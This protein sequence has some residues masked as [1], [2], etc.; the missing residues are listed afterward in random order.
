MVRHGRY[1]FAT[2]VVG[3]MCVQ[4]VAKSGC[5]GWQFI[6]I[7]ARESGRQDWQELSFI[8]A[9]KNRFHKLLTVWTPRRPGSWVNRLGRRREHGA[10]TRRGRGLT[11]NQLACQGGSMRQSISTGYCQSSP[12]TPPLHHIAPSA[13]LGLDVWPRPWAPSWGSFWGLGQHCILGVTT[14]TKR[15]ARRTLHGKKKVCGVHFR[16]LI[17]WM[18]RQCLGLGP[19]WSFTPREGRQVRQLQGLRTDATT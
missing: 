1:L 14:T 15:P 6:Q 2:H 5:G 4:V 13:G 8:L 3:R 7:A 16:T 17:V 19:S 18:R 9:P 10:Q 11:W 12:A